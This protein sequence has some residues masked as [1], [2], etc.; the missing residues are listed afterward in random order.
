MEN[1]RWE[2]HYTKVCEI[3]V[4][5]NFYPESQSKL[6]QQTI[7]IYILGDE[8][9]KKLLMPTNEPYTPSSPE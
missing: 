4:V 9:I 3:N 6:K 8:E 2:L 1:R 5:N 7:W